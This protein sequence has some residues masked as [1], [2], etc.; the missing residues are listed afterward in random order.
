MIKGQHL[1]IA[2]SDFEGCDFHAFPFFFLSLDI[3]KGMDVIFLMPL[4]LLH[5]DL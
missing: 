3:Q 2:I 4:E 5:F 1:Q